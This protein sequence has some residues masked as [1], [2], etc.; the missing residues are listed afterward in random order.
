MGE[1]P[2]VIGV[3]EASLL[4]GCSRSTVLRAIHGGLVPA[5]RV[6]RDYRLRMDALLQT[7]WRPRAPTNR[8]PS[9]RRPA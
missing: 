4:F 6:G 5:E 2:R 8:L 1:L 3:T 7:A 9:N